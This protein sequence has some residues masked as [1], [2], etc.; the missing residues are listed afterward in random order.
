LQQGEKAW[1]GRLVGR[2][3]GVSIFVLCQGGMEGYRF[4]DA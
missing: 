2:L 1:L 4:E 3:G